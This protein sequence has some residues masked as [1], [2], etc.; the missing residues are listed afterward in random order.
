MGALTSLSYRL[1]PK[2]TISTFANLVA[3]SYNFFP[4]PDLVTCISKTFAGSGL[5]RCEVND[6]DDHC[7]IWVSIGTLFRPPNGQVYC[8]EGRHQI[9]GREAIA[10][11]HFPTTRQC[12]AFAER[13]LPATIHWLGLARLREQHTIASDV[14]RCCQSSLLHAFCCILLTA[15]PGTANRSRSAMARQTFLLALNSLS[16]HYSH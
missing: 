9:A 14:L 15:T 8:H 7:R 5:T 1:Q 13:M 11:T 16:R 4:L 12:Q 3:Q 6:S 10:H 2:S